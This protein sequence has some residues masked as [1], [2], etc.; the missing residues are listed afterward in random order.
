MEANKKQLDVDKFTEFVNR[1]ANIILQSDSAEDESPEDSTSSESSESSESS[2]S[3]ENIIENHLNLIDLKLVS[4]KS[5]LDEVLANQ[6]RILNILNSIQTSY[7]SDWFTKYLEYQDR[8]KEKR[9]YKDNPY[10]PLKIWCSN[11]SLE[12]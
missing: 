10:E 2:V 6:N 4:L 3:S 12:K 1:L 7:N 9:V 5:K 8:Q 11:S